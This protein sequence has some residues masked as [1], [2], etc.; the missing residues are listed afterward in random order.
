[1][2]QIADHA[3]NVTQMA[4]A[5]QVA[6]EQHRVRNAAGLPRYVVDQSEWDDI[7]ESVLHHLRGA[8]LA[9][10]QGA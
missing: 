1:M 3:D 9:K 8:E 6:M 2:S 7:A 10:A 5:I 4:I